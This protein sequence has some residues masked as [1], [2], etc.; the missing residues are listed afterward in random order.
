MLT[1]DYQFQVASRCQ[2]LQYLTSLPLGLS[3]KHAKDLLRFRAVTA[4]GKTM[5]RH[6]T[7]L[8]PGDVVTIAVR[9]QVPDTALEHHQLRIV[10]LDNS[11]VV[12]DKPPG[13]LSMGSAR[14]EEERQYG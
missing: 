12:V 7:E 1:A 13:L 10:H 9:R 14:E 8:Q 11:I 5:V 4:Q 2:L 6:D 3:R